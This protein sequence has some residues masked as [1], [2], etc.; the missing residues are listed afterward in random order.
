M[1]S[2]QFLSRREGQHCLC[3]GGFLAGE[4]RRLQRFSFERGG[5]ESL[6]GIDVIVVRHCLD[7]CYSDSVKIQIVVFRFL[8]LFVDVQISRL[9]L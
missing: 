4:S 8:F 7:E 3:R 9:L 6:Y 1:N 2:R 5:F